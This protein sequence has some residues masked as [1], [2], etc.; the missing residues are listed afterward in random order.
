M[1]T[2]NITATIKT[3]TDPANLYYDIDLYKVD[4]ASNKINAFASKSTEKYQLLIGNKTQLHTT[5][6]I[7]DPPETCYILSI[8]IYRKVGVDYIKMT[9]EPMTA[10]AP[11]KGFL[12]VANNNFELPTSPN[13]TK[14]SHDWGLSR[15]FEYYETTQKNQKSENGQVNTVQ[16][17]ISSKPRVFVVKN[18]AINSTE[19]PFTRKK[20]EDELKVRMTRPE[21]SYEQMLG[22]P[23][24]DIR[25]RVL[26]YPFQDRSCLCGPASF[27]IVC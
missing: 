15:E 7:A 17:Y 11:L 23:F 20:I 6:E 3:N 25:R 27:F 12:L 18:C 10:I 24:E 14:E 1:A 16:L 9:Q 5:K 13:T 22:L 26:S 19:D 8:N 2:Y 21:I 4:W